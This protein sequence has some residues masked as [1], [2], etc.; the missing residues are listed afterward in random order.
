MKTMSAMSVD[1]ASSS[2]MIDPP[3][4]TTTTLSWNRWM[5]DSAST[6][7]AA[8][9]IAASIIVLQ[10]PENE[11]GASVG[12]PSEPV[13]SGFGLSGGCQT[14]A[15]VALADVPGHPLPTHR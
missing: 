4:L 5:Y 9:G 3:T 1:S 14:G 12:W 2:S 8:L 6:S 13:K 7:A 15:W 10:S 11:K